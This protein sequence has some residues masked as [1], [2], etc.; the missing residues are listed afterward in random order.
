[1][2][3]IASI[4]LLAAVIAAGLVAPPNAR[5]QLEDQLLLHWSGQGELSFPVVPGYTNY[6]VEWA[7]TAQGPWTNSWEQLKQL[8]PSGATQT[9]RVPMFYRVRALGGRVT[10]PTGMAYVPP[11]EFLMGDH[12]A[13]APDALP[14]RPVTVRAFFID[15][16]EVSLSHWQEV[17]QW[18]VA[19]GYAFD[20]FGQATAANH[21]VNEITWYD[22]IKWCN[23]RSEKEGLTPAYST[24]ATQTA[25][26][27]LGQLD[28][29]RACVNWS[30]D[31]YRLPTEAEWEK[32]ARGGLAGQQYPWPSD[33]A[34]H[35][36]QIKGSQANYW[37]SGD[38]YDNGTTP[39]GFY[40]GH[41]TV[42]G[43]N[44]ANGLGLY[45]MAGDVA[46]MCWDWYGPYP[47]GA[48]VDPVGPDTGARRVK[49]GGSWYDDPL[50]LRCGA[51][52]SFFP[53]LS[54]ATRGFR[55]V[56][57]ISAP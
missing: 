3:T 54:G 20:S 21:P 31:A 51:R 26:Y 1:M 34:N 50:A 36:T 46:E 13:I 39:V 53:G 32:A 42:G 9:V 30:G 27:R 55:C 17:A 11:G 49:R 38:P 15:Q 40:D 10:A 33:A 4:S 8:T 24:D 25:V 57:S 29:D 45:D 5:A 28:L 19:H 6:T 14:V 22:A 44:M 12:F 56:R 52:A 43:R 7:P 41:Q 23:A 47:A 37:S 35:T 2:K 18:A 16:R 48:A